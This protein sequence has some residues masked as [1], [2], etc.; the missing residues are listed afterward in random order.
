MVPAAIAILLLSVAGSGADRK[1]S[2]MHELRMARRECAQP[3]AKLAALV[4]RSFDQAEFGKEVV[5]GWAALSVEQRRAFESLADV[6]VGSEKRS[7]YVRELCQTGQRVRW[8]GKLDDKITRVKT[9]FLIE[10][11]EEHAELW[12]R[13]DGDRWTFVGS[14][15]CGADA[16]LLSWR[17]RLRGGYHAA[18]AEL[19][20][21]AKE[22]RGLDP[23]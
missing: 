9:T 23:R 3:G 2:A 6:V 5:S 10:G 14:W 22:R 17:Q 7:R 13:D 8:V 15:C 18:M 12:F 19:Q 16:F 4:G 20:A 21:R 11:L 1:G